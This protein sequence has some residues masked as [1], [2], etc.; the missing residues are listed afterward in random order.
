MK[1]FAP[2]LLKKKK[3]KK[4]KKKKYFYGLFNNHHRE[5]ILIQ[6]LELV[7]LRDICIQLKIET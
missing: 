3:T 2:F 6:R 4:R 5:D 7:S 1:G